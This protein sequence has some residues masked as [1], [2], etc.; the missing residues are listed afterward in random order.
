MRKPR[1]QPLGDRKDPLTMR[2]G[3]EH[4]RAQPFTELNHPFLMAGGT[5]VPSLA[6]KCQKVFMAAIG[7]ADPGKAV[8]KIAAV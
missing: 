4:L 1:P 7:T 5:E 3:F 2:D 8:V 6:G